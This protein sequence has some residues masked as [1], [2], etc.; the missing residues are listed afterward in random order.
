M[1]SWNSDTTEQPWNEDGSG[2]ET[3]FDDEEDDD[4]FGFDEED[5]D[6]FEENDD[7]GFD[8]DDDW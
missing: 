4:G 2:V 8:D 6:D 5:E 7:F 1:D 3:D